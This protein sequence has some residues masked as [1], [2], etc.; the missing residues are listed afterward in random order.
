[1]RRRGSENL[2]PPIGMSDHAPQ[3]FGT[4]IKCRLTEIKCFLSNL[5]SVY[6][7]CIPVQTTYHLQLVVS[8]TFYEIELTI[9]TCASNLRDLR[10]LNCDQHL[11]PN[12]SIYITKS[13]HNSMS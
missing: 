4:D 11:C 5:L 8:I 10:S 12:H 13:M 1:M 6:I 2:A 9:G 3:A 7:L